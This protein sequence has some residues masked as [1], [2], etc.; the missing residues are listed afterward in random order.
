MKRIFLLLVILLTLA[1]CE[2]EQNSA[3]L[4][5]GIY[6]GTFI[7]SSPNVRYAPSK[8]TLTLAN[9]TFT[10]SSDTN[11]Y[12]AICTG[13]FTVVGNMINTT[14]SCF[15]TA[16]FDWTFIFNGE[17]DYEVEGNKLTLSKSFPGSVYDRY[18]LEKQ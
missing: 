2:K 15:F 4:A 12:P 13:T 3:L 5:D 10:G 17:F 14:N 16:D 9:N 7:R 11:N 8:V 18:I 6:K 1:A